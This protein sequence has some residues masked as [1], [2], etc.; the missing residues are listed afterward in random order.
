MLRAYRKSD[1][2]SQSDFVKTFFKT[3]NTVLEDE[4]VST[5]PIRI[6][7]LNS[8]NTTLVELILDENEEVQEKEPCND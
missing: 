5:N 6:F 4:N 7:R 2:N 8:D 3:I 1:P